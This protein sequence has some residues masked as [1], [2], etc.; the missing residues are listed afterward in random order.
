MRE[1]ILWGVKIGAEDWEE[2]LIVSTTNV[3]R[4]AKARQWAIANGFD[5]LRESSFTPGERPNFG[6]RVRG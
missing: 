5:R 6:K 1:T 3:E 2:Q 4:L